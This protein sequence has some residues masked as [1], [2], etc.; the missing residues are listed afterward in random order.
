MNK[1]QM[2]PFCQTDVTSSA[3]L[4]LF[5]NKVLDKKNL[6]DWFIVP[7]FSVLN[8]STNTWQER[9]KIWMKRIDDKAQARKNKLTMKAKSGIGLQQGIEFMSIK[10]DTTSILD[11]VLCEVLLHWFTNENHKCFDPF[12]GDAV[13]GFCSAYK[14]R[15]FIGIE[16]RSEQVEFNQTLID[17][18]GLDGRYICDDAVNVTKHIE[19]ESVD[20]IFS[21]PPYA[22][23]EI[24]SDLENDLSNMDYDVFF[25]TIDKVFT[26]CY[27]RLKNNRFAAIVIGEVRHKNTGVYLGLVPKITKIMM[28]AGFNY[29]NEMILATPIGNLHMRA[30]NYMSGSRKIGK[31]HQN[32]LIFYKGNTKFI[33]KEFKQL[34]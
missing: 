8:V 5:G 11:P 6:S 16:L 13:F 31:Q 24:Y 1:E 15:P 26:D 14:N 27:S 9:K 12:A 3:S 21:C 28:D 7:P 18:H 20:F 34:K 25:N 19:R 2:P 33:K 30:G 32:V 4:D 23:L 10:G 17:L 29:Y 22:D